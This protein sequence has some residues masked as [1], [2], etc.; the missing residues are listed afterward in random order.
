[1]TVN[2]TIFLL[3]HAE[4][5]QTTPDEQREL[6]PRGIAS[7]ANLVAKIERKQF[8]RIKA[9]EHSPWKRA[10]KTAELFRQAAGLDALPLVTCEHILPNSN[11]KQSAARLASALGDRLFIG[12]NPHLELLGSIL[13]G[14]ERIGIQIAMPPA[15]LLALERF[16]PQNPRY[17]YG[18]WQLRLLV[19]PDEDI[20]D[21]ADNLPNSLF[22]N[23]S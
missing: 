6:T 10:T 11:A 3:R 16:V 14:Q 4:A 12:H 8:A 7:I 21:I 15:A 23:N 2:P 22:S 19:A 5:A 20:A 13:L 18:C 9:I 1:M 17:P